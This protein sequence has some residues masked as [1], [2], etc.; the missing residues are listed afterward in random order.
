MDQINDSAKYQH[1]IF[2]VF[3]YKNIFNLFK[4]NNIEGFVFF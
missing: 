4:K 3:Y 1:F 2:G